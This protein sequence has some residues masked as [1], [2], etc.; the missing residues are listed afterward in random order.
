MMFF[1]WAF[2]CAVLIIV[3]LLAV[4]VYELIVETRQDARHYE[5]STQN[6][7]LKHL[8]HINNGK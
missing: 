8:Q 4:G 2:G 1:Y 7:H 6:L 3:T 5:E